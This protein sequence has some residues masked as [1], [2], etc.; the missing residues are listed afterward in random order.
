MNVEEDSRGLRVLRVFDGS[1]AANAGIRKQDLIVP[2]N[3]RSIAGLSSEVATG[4]IKGPA[5]TRVS[6]RCSR[7][8]GEDTRTVRVE[9]ERIEVPGRDRA[10]GRARRP[11][12]RRGRAAQLQ[13]GR[14]RAAAPR[15]RRAARPGRGG[16]R[17][18]PARQRRR[19][20]LGGA[21][22][23]RASS[24]RTARSCRCAGA[25]APERTEDA[26]ATRSTRRRPGG[27]AGRRRQR[28]RLRD[29]HRRAARPRAR[30]RGRHAHLRQGPR[31]GGRAALERRRP[32][33][34]G[35][36]LL[37]ARRQDHHHEGHQAAGEG[38][39]RP[40]HRRA[41]RRFRSRSTSCSTSCE[42]G[43]PRPPGAAPRPAAG[44]R[45]REARPLPRR[46][47]AVRPRAAHR[48][49]ARRRRARATWCWSARASAAP[50]WCA[51]WAGPT[52]RAT[53]WRA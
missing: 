29:R 19:P 14:A 25:T 37:P 8:G 10:G 41:T 33:P 46:R 28:Q 4:R 9:R 43:S 2:V 7:P 27:R 47:A 53:C 52:G 22:S 12:A 1:P 32:R 11:E 30:D 49:R 26:R 6:S 45:A 40:E 38:R 34:H 3:G 42:R 13:L 31:P 21:C 15:G 24:S 50:A 16:D 44:R 18:R 39:R 5:G 17:A 23:C 51:G 48:G 36:Q 35:R 20:A